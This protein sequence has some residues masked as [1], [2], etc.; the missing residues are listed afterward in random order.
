MLRSLILFSLLL[1]F[2][3]SKDA[4]VD[5]EE[6]QAIELA[7][8]ADPQPIPEQEVPTLAVGSP[9]PD[10]NLPDANGQMRSLAD[11]TAAKTLVLIFT[12]N[13]CPTAQ[14]YEDR[15]IALANDYDIADMQLVAIS[16][17]SPL[18][19][20][21][22][23]QGYT[24][25]NDDFAALAPRAAHKGYNFPYLY[26]GDTHAAS[27]LYGPVATPH[28]FLLDEDRQ[29]VYT[30]RLDSIERPGQ[31]NAEDLRAAIDAVLAGQS[32]PEA[33]TKTFGCST[34]WAW[35]T[36]YKGQVQE[37]W[38]ARAVELGR[39]DETAVRQLIANESGS[40]LRLI[41]LWA[42]WCGPCVLEYPD[43]LE[44]QRIYGN[45]DFEFISLSA[46]KPDQ[47]D[48]VLRFLQ[49]KN[50]GIANY[51][52]D[53]DNNYALIEA[54]DPDWNGALPYTILVDPEGEI[55][56]RHQGTVDLLELRRTIVEHPLLGR[57]F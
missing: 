21:L 26:D 20:L 37:Q 32:P 19:L 1:L 8:S 28:A 31:A 51:L 39:L 17:N 25:L 10:F 43:L 55:L 15:M 27:L 47:Y 14:A 30:G 49:E 23:E 48:K 18:G 16:C 29:L 36:E 3:C 24:D 44:L 2:A 35:K 12:A 33:T 34:K 40:K 52:F 45:R 38:E 56:Y 6:D 5:Q 42:T 11:Y 13:H 7:F 53:Q 46:D 54:V 9:A 4:T 22:E 57:Y 50:S 41:N